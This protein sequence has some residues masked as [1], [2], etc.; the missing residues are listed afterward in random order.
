MSINMMARNIIGCLTFTL[1]TFALLLFV[2]SAT[3]AN[4][5]FS[6]RLTING[7]D[8]SEMETIVIDP[9]QELAI[10]LQIF[11]VTR[12]ITLQKVSVVVI[13]AGQAILT[14]SNTLGNFRMMTGESYRHEMTI[15]AREVLKLGN[16]PLATGIYRSQIRLEYSVDGQEKVWSQWKNIKILGNPLSTPLGVAGMVVS[17]GAVAAI[18][19]LVRSLAVPSLPAGTT[20]PL[21][22]SVKAL[23][24]LYELALE[25][26]EPVTR[27]R[28]V[29]SIVNSAKKRI[30]KEKCPICQTHLKHGYCYTCQKSAKEVR[31]EYTN[32]LKSLVLQGGQLVASGQVATLEDLCSRLSLSHK[33]GSDVMA[34][35]RHAKLVKL[36]GVSRKLTG[37]AVLAGI[38]SGLSTMIWVT[39]G[40]FAVLSASALILI[41][42]ASI[43]IPFAIT[44]SLQIKAR[45]AIRR[46]AK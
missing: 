29:G 26:L 6:L 14:Q 12:D 37:K 39:V 17:A 35:L 22:A 46:G 44:K 19:S 45:R 3:K 34:T 38:S 16:L 25:R 28:V 33:L 13:F 9:E 43:I 18:L 21:S 23:P 40:G 36:R 24:R 2:N 27:G 41:L 1:L 15:N 42:I 7:D 8:V 32:K 20:L 31:N 11:D 30:K 4:D 10:D 5:D